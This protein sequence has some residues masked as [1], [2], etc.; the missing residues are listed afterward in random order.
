MACLFIMAITSCL[1]KIIPDKGFSLYTDEEMVGVLI[2]G[3][4]KK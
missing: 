1:I 4:I 2:E 3:G